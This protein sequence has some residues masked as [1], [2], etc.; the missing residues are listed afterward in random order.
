[1]PRY[2]FNCPITWNIGVPARPELGTPPRNLF[3]FFLSKISAVD[4]ALIFFFF[5]LLQ[6]IRA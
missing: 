6:R 2:H 5:L 4:A 3:F 1:M